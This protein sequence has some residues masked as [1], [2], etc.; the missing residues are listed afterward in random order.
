MPARTRARS[1]ATS[2][3]TWVAAGPPRRSRR[4]R[5]PTSTP[6]CPGPCADRGAFRSRR[7]RP[8]PKRRLVPSV[9]VRHARPTDRDARDHRVAGLGLR[10]GQSVPASP[11][12]ACRS[13]GHC[14][15]ARANRRGDSPTAAPRP[16]AFQAVRLAGRRV[17]V[18]HRGRRRLDP[19]RHPRRL[20]G[21]HGPRG[22]YAHMLE[23]KSDHPTAV[24]NLSE[25]TA[26]RHRVSSSAQQRRPSAAT[27]SRTLT[28]SSSRT[29]TTTLR[30]TQR[31]RVRRRSW[32]WDDYPFLGNV[33]YAAKY[34]KACADAVAD[35]Y[36]PAW[37][38]SITGSSRCGTAGRPC[39]RPRH[40]QRLHRLVRA[41]WLRGR[42][43]TTRPRSSRLRD[44]RQTW[45]RMV[46]ETAEA[47]GFGCVGRLHL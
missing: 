13:R 47:E 45:N 5:A 24:Q 1:I 8:S 28:S 9:P 25:P 40:I 35:A 42:R 43:A 4:R 27:P 26:S 15:D 23:S 6:S 31:R 41:P 10:G 33:P 39:P 30:G 11:Y 12:Q 19:A 20:P 21:L 36:R 37:R 22:P 2:C 38:R 14:R 16:S 7:S 34:T 32:V 29:A 18:A 3:S 17:H 44:S 46:C